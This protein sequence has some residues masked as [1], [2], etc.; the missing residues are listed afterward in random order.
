MS[1]NKETRP[2][3]VLMVSDDHGREAVGCYG[4]HVINTP[5]MDALA[6]D[7]VRFLN[8]CC[9]TA[10]C[11][12]SRTVMLTGLQ[13]HTTGCYG[14]THKAHHFS[15]FD[16]IKTL[17][18]YLHE[19]GYRTGRVGK[20]HY[21]P[22]SLFPFHWNGPDTEHGRDDVLMSKVCREFIQ[23]D[24]PFFLHWCSR[25][26]HRAFPREDH[27]LQ[28]DN[29]GNPTESFEGDQEQYYT[30]EEV[31]VPPFLSDTP[32]VRA[33][34]AQYYQSISRLDRGIGALIEMMK[35]EG[36]YENTLFIYI[37]DNGAAFP[38]SKTTLYDPGMR[39][40]C[41]VRSPYNENRGGTCDG[42]V[43]W[44][45][46]TPTILD[47]AGM[48]DCDG[49]FFGKSFKRIIDQE[50][51]EDWRDEIFAAHSLHGITN[52]Y[53]MRV[54]RT[55][56]YKFIV[57][58]AWKLD[59]S[60]ASDL[61]SSASWQRAL[62]DGAEVFGTRTIDAYVH[63]PKFELYDLQADPDETVNLAY[64]ADKKLLVEEFT[65]K[66]KAFQRETNDPWYHKWTYE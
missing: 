56:R 64:E 51:P 10:S 65:E 63:R 38:V 31:L 12:P 26:P 53:P 33:E 1:T 15:C 34:L 59:Y 40:P 28:P 47:F 45:D 44:A 13:N 41:I 25:N 55:Q 42:L 50:S 60:F 27:P 39:L 52:Y 6:A 22:E 43:T 24:E 11:A 30:E 32:E 4:N 66:I 16:N 58:I 20:R 9:T 46:L 61:Y 57:N 23:G 37:S 5:H 17:T 8:G 19:L 35:Q 48:Q 18:M 49:P 54:L 36:K 3:I 29:F 62:R 21:Q 2:N 7:G 14:L